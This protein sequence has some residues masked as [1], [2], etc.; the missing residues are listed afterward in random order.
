M[1][2]FATQTRAHISAR[3]GILAPGGHRPRGCRSVRHRS[4]LS[5]AGA[6]V[7]LERS[8]H[9]YV[10]HEHGFQLQLLRAVLDEDRSGHGQRQ[11]GEAGT[12]LA[13]DPGE[14][15][16]TDRGL[17]EGLQGALGHQTPA[18][19]GQERAARQAR[20]PGEY[21]RDHERRDQ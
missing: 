3:S 2:L 6:A 8:S 5:P 4:R 13:L 10:R 7:S 19:Q 11:P 20:V 16:Q 14:H 1:K 21:V 9:R 18:K 12:A 17:R 15:S